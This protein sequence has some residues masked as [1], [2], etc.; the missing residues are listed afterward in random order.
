MVCYHASKQSSTKYGCFSYEYQIIHPLHAA[1]WG[2]MKWYCKPNFVFV[3]LKGLWRQ[4]KIFAYHVFLRMTLFSWQVQDS[5]PLGMSILLS[6]T[7]TLS[8]SCRGES[9]I[10]N[11]TSSCLIPLSYSQSCFIGPYPSGFLLLKFFATKSAMPHKKS[12]D[13]G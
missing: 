4:Y 6:T 12:L 5:M 11:S 2:R 7:L 13:W 3:L 8:V 10:P 1:V 9:S